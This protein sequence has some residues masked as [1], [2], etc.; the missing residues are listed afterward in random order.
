MNDVVMYVILAVIVFCGDAY[1]YLLGKR[2][3]IKKRDGIFVVNT[4]DPEKDVFKLEIEVPVSVIPTK[5]Y[6]IFHV[7]NESSQE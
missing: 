6:L 5:K 4:T 3:A 7:T 2:N 1:F